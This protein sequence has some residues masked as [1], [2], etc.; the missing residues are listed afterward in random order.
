MIYSWAAKRIVLGEDDLGY[1]HLHFLNPLLPA[2]TK[3]QQKILSNNHL[4]IIMLWGRCENLSYHLIFYLRI[5]TR[6][7]VVYVY[8]YSLINHS[9]LVDCVTCAFCST[10]SQMK[11]LS[12]FESLLIK[13]AFTSTDPVNLSLIRCNAKKTT[14]IEIKCNRH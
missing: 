7:S 10:C 2:P 4:L 9:T 11:L 13:H 12:I 14:T 1:T 8:V 5:V 6:N 3:K